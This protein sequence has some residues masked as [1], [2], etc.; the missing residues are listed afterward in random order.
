MSRTRLSELK[1]PNARTSIK[2][3]RKLY[4]ARLAELRDKLGVQEE[5]MKCVFSRVA[6]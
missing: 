2:L 6:A 4:I 3:A 5:Q 1:G